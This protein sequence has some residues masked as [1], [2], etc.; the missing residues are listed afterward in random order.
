MAIDSQPS[1]L[2][3]LIHSVPHI[4]TTFNFVN[5]TFEPKSLV[6]R[7]VSFQLSLF[8]F[9]L[10]KLRNFYSYRV[11]EFWQPYQLRF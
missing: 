10:N 7:E 4:N 8:I 1:I 9:K 3:R 11:W 5:D 6:Y 2:V